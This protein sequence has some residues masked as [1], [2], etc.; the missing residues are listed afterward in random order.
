M[1]RRCLALVLGAVCGMS[2]GAQPAP[3]NAPPAGRGEVEILSDHFDY[4]SQTRVIVCDG[5][6]RVTDPQMQLTCKVLTAHMADV[7]NQITNIVATGS[8]VIDLLGEQGP[9]HATSDKAVYN[10][11]TDLVELTGNPVLKTRQ[12]TLTGDVVVLDRGKN[13]LEARGHVRMLMPPEAL[14]QPGLLTATNPPPRAVT[15][16]HP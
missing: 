10:A 3:T 4:A 2:T 12:G 15:K 11:A 16:P 14:K 9:S 8:V 5:N 6:V 7:G 13:R 1:K